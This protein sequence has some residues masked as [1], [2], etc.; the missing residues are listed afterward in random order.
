MYNL[1]GV[2]DVC[3][4][5]DLCL[6]IVVGFIIIQLVLSIYNTLTLMIKLQLPRI[7]SGYLNYIYIYDTNNLLYIMYIYI[8]HNIIIRV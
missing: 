7:D 4:W 5:C 8:L 1:K 6:Y 3:K 2:C